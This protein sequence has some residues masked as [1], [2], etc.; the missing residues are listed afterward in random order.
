VRG[1]DL[2]SDAL[3][4]DRLGVDN[5]LAEALPAL[6][7]DWSDVEWRGK[8]PTAELIAGFKGHVEER[9]RHDTEATGTDP[10]N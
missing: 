6:G 7:L 2:Y 8:E 9:R 4:V 10:G 1:P 5:L 3:D